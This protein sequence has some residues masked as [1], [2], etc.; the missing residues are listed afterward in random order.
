M[1]LSNIL[2]N[3][4]QAI[5]SISTL[6]SMR[7]D[8]LDA[9]GVNN[10]TPEEIEALFSA[11]PLEF[12]LEQIFIEDTISDRLKAQV[13]D[14]IN[15]RQGKKVKSVKEASGSYNISSIREDD[16]IISTREQNT[17]ARE[18]NTIVNAREQDSI[19]NAREQDA[20]T[21]SSDISESD[22]T[23]TDIFSLRDEVIKDYRSY[24][25]GFLNIRD[26]T[27]KQFVKKALD[28]GY[29]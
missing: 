26:D 24:I 4:Q 14:Y 22:I 29:L 11:I 25:E 20:L 23:P 5:A 9:T 21:P 19:V 18:Q 7:L 3:G 12:N 27:I 17:N 13:T 10:L 15:Q 1:L 16:R 2:A 8:K 6:I 28:D